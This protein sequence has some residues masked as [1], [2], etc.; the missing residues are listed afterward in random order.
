M[1]IVGFTIILRAFAFI[2]EVSP[3]PPPL[4]RP[5]YRAVTLPREICTECFERLVSNILQGDKMLHFAYFIC[6][7]ILIPLTK[8]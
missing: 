1:L 8:G 2:F 5:C 6:I 4:S 7:F 3:P